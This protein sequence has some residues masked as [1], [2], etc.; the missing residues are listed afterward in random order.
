MPTYLSARERL[1]RTASAA[2]V[3]AAQRSPYAASGMH[4]AT[5]AACHTAASSSFSAL[6]GASHRWMWQSHAGPSSPSKRFCRLAECQPLRAL[7]Q[8]ARFSMTLVHSWQSHCAA[9]RFLTHG[10]RACA[11]WA[12]P[13]FA[14]CGRFFVAVS[15]RKRASNSDLT[16]FAKQNVEVARLRTPRVQVVEC[17]AV[18]VD[19]QVDSDL[20]LVLVV[21]IR[22][23]GLSPQ[24]S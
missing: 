1:R 8:R 10:Q 17:V 2:N 21:R 15:A 18:R 20:L 11:S 13:S 9:L 12:R 23:L 3:A 22:V 5:A 7:C 19:A 24:Q 6:D 16:K 14:P 4:A